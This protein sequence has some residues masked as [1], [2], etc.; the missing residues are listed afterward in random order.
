M[1]A[2]CMGM[3]E[4]VNLFGN[5]IVSDVSSADAVGLHEDVRFGPVAQTAC[6]ALGLAVLCCGGAQLAAER[7]C[8]N[9]DDSEGLPASSAGGQVVGERV[10]RR[11]EQAHRPLGPWL[12]PLVGKAGVGVSQRVF[13]ANDGLGDDGG[14]AIGAPADAPASEEG[15]AGRIPVAVDAAF[16]RVVNH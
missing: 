14:V 8:A 11:L 10:A 7:G 4:S 9:R 6:Q 5:R 3:G 16:V 15:G 12:C 13:V 1:G 2:L